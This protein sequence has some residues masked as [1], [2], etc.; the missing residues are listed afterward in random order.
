MQKKYGLLTSIAMIVGI[1]IGSGIFFKSDDILVFTNNNVLLGIVIFCIA[2]VS[3]IFGSLSVAQLASKTDEHGGIITYAEKFIHPCL[4][5]VMGWFQTFLYYPTIIVVVS[6]VCGIYTCQLFNVPATLEIEVA[7]GLSLVTILYA[8]NILAAKFGGHLQSVAMIIKLVPLFL[9][10]VLGIAFGNPAETVFADSG[11][12]FSNVGWIAAVVPIAFSFDGW[13]VAT[14]VGHEIKNSKRNLPLALIISPLIILAIYIA[15]FVGVTSLLD[16]ETVSSLGNGHVDAMASQIFGHNGSKIVLTF[17]VI[18]V[19]GTV[20]GLS[21]GNMR[22]PYALSMRGTFPKSKLVKKINTKINMPINSA[23]VSFIII[24]FWYCVHY[25]VL[26]LDLMPNGDISEISI[27]L[28]YVFFI[29]LYAAV[30]KLCINGE[31]ENKFVGIVSPI[32]AT[33]GSV[34][35]FIGGLYNPLFL[36]YSLTCLVVVAVSILFYIKRRNTN[37]L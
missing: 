12:I 28:N 18:S 32:I 3:I 24:L 25:I 23:V 6:W 1:V 30:I 19:L 37:I 8:V 29:F 20:N 13:I 35:I 22:M 31:I 14:S 26:K 34:A 5:C 17:V 36:Y 11:A 4:G 9:F 7:I 21:I 16:P 27:V 33:L 15:Y 2:A 10:A